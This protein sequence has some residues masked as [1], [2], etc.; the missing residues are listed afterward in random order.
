M[1]PSNKLP[2]PPSSLTP[3]ARAAAPPA[4]RTTA[5]AG[6][7]VWRM[8]LEESY[9]EQLKSPVADLKNTGGRL[10]GSITAALFLKE[11]VKTDKVGAGGGAAARDVGAAGD[12]WAAAACGC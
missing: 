4:P 2:A 11:F 7:K 6:E 8:P 1:C 12:A 10:G 9:M 3:A 5:A